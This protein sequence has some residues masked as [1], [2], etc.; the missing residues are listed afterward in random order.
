[1]IVKVPHVVDRDLNPDSLDAN[2]PALNDIFYLFI[3]HFQ[4]P[5]HPVPACANDT[6][7]T[8]VKQEPRPNSQSG[9]KRTL[10][11]SYSEL[12]SS[13]SKKGSPARLMLG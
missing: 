1:M 9:L 12:P 13:Q 2:V 4:I 8:P 7:S 3:I 5:A 10:S 11:K 6:Q